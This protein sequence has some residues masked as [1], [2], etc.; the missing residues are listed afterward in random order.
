MKEIFQGITTQEGREL[1]RKSGLL[2]HPE[3][4]LAF[5]IAFDTMR[6]YDMLLY[7]F[8]EEA[9]IALQGLAFSEQWDTLA[10]CALAPNTKNPEA[11]EPSTDY[12]GGL[13]IKSVLETSTIEATIMFV[14]VS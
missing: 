12:R 13:I 3:W 4:D 7:N 1:V 2:L 6:R 14:N 8:E 10:I 11:T 9:T 5:V